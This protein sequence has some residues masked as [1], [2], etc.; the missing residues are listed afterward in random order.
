VVAEHSEWMGQGMA[1]ATV[2][3]NAD[4][5]GDQRCDQDDEPEDYDHDALRG[6]WVRA[7][8][9]DVASPAGHPCQRPGLLPGLRR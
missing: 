6:G 8:S 1:A 5:A 7:S 3:E 2:G 4:H 9:G